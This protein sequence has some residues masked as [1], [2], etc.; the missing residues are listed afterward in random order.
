MTAREIIAEE[1]EMADF[2]AAHWDLFAE[3]SLREAGVAV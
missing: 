3:A 2:I 1:R